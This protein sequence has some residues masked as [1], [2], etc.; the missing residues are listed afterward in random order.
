MGKALGVLL[1]ILV[2][3]TVLLFIAHNVGAPTW[4]FPP[5]ISEHGPAYDT[6]FAH[7]LWVVA[8]AFILAQCALGYVVFRFGSSKPGR[9]TYSHGSNKLETIWTIVTA[10]VFITLAVLGQRVWASLHFH[11]APPGSMTVEVTGE[12][13]AWNFRY[14]GPDGQFGRTDPKLMDTS[15]GN[16]V[17]LVDD[18]PAGKDDFVT[19][20]LSIPVGRPVHLILKSKDVIH[21]FFVPNL[22][23][24]QDM[25]PG[26]GIDVHFTP[27]QTGRFEITCA[28]LCGLGHYKMKTFLDVMSEDDFAKWLKEKETK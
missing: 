3:G 4:W 26:M 12:Q 10:V 16:P 2:L 1:W 11:E 5:A 24:K 25:V 13:F 21:S 9:A 7:T 20:T 14:P 27:T 19:S 8:A 6:Q 28:E 17:G 23:F 18:D 15:A 22:R